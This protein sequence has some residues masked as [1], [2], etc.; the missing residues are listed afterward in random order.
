MN[1]AIRRAN[2]ALQEINDVLRILDHDRAALGRL[3]DQSD[4][5]DSRARAPPRAGHE[6]HRPLRSSRA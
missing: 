1:A 4:R 3:V 5:V 6:L 2:P